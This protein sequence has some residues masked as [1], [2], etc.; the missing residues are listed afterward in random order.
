MGETSEIMRKRIFYAA[1]FALFVLIE[2]LIALFVH[3]R[4]IRPY[5][6]DVIVEWVLYCLVMAVFPKTDPKYVPVF[7][8]LFSCAVE[9]S[10]LF[11]LVYALGLG[12]SRFFR[13]LLGTSFSFVD[14]LCYFAGCAIIYAARFAF[15]FFIRKKGEKGKSA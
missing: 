5:G 2:V 14:I 9:L 12:E 7:I 6:G 15:L 13:T 4:F 3:D 1:G 11:G 8:F 10:Q